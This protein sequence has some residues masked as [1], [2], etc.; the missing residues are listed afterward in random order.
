M[1]LT[2]PY[3]ILILLI[4][5]GIAAFAASPFIAMKNLANMV[6]ANNAEQ[7]TEQVNTDY[8][9][10][11]TYK[12]MDGLLRG[13]MH[14]EINSRQKS[15]IEAMQDFSFSKSVSF[16]QVTKL[17]S[18]KG[19][20]HLVCAEIARFP[21][22]PLDDQNGCWKMEGELNWQ[23][24]ARVEVTYKN[25]KT[26]WSTHLYFDRTGLFNWQVV[27]IAMPVKAMM[28]Q[29]KQQIISRSHALRVGMHTGVL[30]RPVTQSVTHCIPP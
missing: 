7:W 11:Y 1:K 27:D 19:F 13:K 22:R 3:Q 30:L 10:E 23:S 18:P 12:L 29:L 4:V 28:M 24:P 21:E 16:R 14:L 25:P 17:V 2:W 8:L 20:S 6:K 5:L 9:Q 15:N 26:G